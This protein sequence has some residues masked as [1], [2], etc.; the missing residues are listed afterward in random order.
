MGKGWHFG[1][2]SVEGESPRFWRMDLEGDAA[3]QAI[4]ELVR[5]RCEKL[6]GGPLRVV[7]QY[8]NGH[9]YG[10]GG[11][12]HV[13]D[14]K[15]GN[16]TLLYY[17]NPEWHDGWDGETVFY[18]AAGEIA[19]AVR[20]R[21]N[22]AVFFDGRIPH[23]GKAPSRACKVLRVS[24]AYKLERSDS[25]PPTQSAA[26][27]AEPSRPPGNLAVWEE[28]SREGARREYRGRCGEA[29]VA[30]AVDARLREIG[31]RIRLPGFRPGQIP[32]AVLQER[33]GNEARAWALKRLAVHSMQQGLPAG[34]VASSCNLT[35]GEDS[36]ALEMAVV[37]THLPDLPAPDFSSVI[38]EQ[39]VADNPAPDQA[40]FLRRHLALQVLNH[41][42]S[43]Y[44]IPLFPGVVDVEF[45]ALWK[46]AE[47]DGG[48]I[49]EETAERASIESQ[50]RS[51]AERRLRLGLIV[52]ELA[53]RFGIPAASGA[54]LE[55][56]TI[57]YLIAHA[58]VRKRRV[59]DRELAEMMSAGGPAA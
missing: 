21:P 2:G 35:A 11:E 47:S 30:Q 37:A 27:A 55:E 54:E 57:D 32:H 7:R 45:Q 58:S 1:H 29:A 16:F 23:C 26:A 25:P 53:R 48:V 17:P 6:A 36:G 50:F 42:D 14:S 51:I 38:I 5:S 18:D 24:V 46:A 20:P 15:P 41:L 33:Y 52:A 3:F 8:A 56:R 43:R 59:S 34:S 28:A 19:L 49:P 39:L 40:A 22:R 12:T 31:R 4:W 44:S 13:D 9:T 10:L